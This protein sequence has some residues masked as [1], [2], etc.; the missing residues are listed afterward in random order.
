[1]CMMR[2]QA[3]ARRREVLKEPERQEHAR[4]TA[5]AGANSEM[6]LGGKAS[7]DLVRSATRVQMSPFS[8]V[9]FSS[10]SN[11]VAS[12]IGQKLMYHAVWAQVNGPGLPMT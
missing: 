12:T 9:R 10:S 2:A 4:C 8:G 7:L 11:C 6:R 3:E 5:A 1:M